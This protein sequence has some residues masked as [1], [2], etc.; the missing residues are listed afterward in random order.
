MNPP[1]AAA[2][3]IPSLQPDPP[4]PSPND[5]RPQRTKE[6]RDA[7]TAAR[8]AVSQS[9]YGYGRPTSDL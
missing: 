7:F 4:T 9:V 8:D 2:A 3:A 1:T 6:G 5:D